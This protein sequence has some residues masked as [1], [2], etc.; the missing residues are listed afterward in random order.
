M[1]ILPIFAS[2]DAPKLSKASSILYYA[3]VSPGVTE[4]LFITLSVSS[5]RD[6]LVI[7][8]VFSYEFEVDKSFK[9]VSS[10]TFFV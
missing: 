10:G 8:L 1:G 2:F 9:L 3:S 7:F 6:D 5:S 4:I